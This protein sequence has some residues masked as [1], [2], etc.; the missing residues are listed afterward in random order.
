MVYSTY[1]SWVINE[2]VCPMCN[3]CYFTV[4]DDVDVHIGHKPLRPS[5][6]VPLVP[7][8]TRSTPTRVLFY[9]LLRPSKHATCD[10]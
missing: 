1:V 2:I 4:L 6:Q 3:V 7:A 8:C 10:F 9:D 5:G